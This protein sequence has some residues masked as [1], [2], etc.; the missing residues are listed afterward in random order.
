MT[1]GK[2]RT[3]TKYMPDD[4]ELLFS[5]G[6]RY[7]DINTLTPIKRGLVLCDKVFEQTDSEGIANSI[8]LLSD[9][10]KI[11]EENELIDST[12]QLRVKIEE[13]I[14]KLLEGRKTHD[15]EKE[16]IAYSEMESLMVATMQQLD[17]LIKRIES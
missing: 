16:C 2:F 9:K 10:G 14:D 12:K 13:C 3:I 17:C 4:T 6:G 15:K 11:K 7:S 1:I 8:F 5:Y